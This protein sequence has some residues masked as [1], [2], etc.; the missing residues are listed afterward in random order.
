MFR[1]RDR[2]SLQRRHPTLFRAADPASDELTDPTVLPTA[3]PLSMTRPIPSRAASTTR[4]IMLFS[5]VLRGLFYAVFDFVWTI[6]ISSP[7][8]VCTPSLS[9]AFCHLDSERY[10]GIS[11][12]TVPPWALCSAR[13][14]FIPWTVASFHERVSQTGTFKLRKGGAEPL[15]VLSPNRGGRFLAAPTTASTPVQSL[16]CRSLSHPLLSQ[17]KTLFRSLPSRPISLRYDFAISFV[18]SPP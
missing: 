6:V 11:P 5:W 17:L 7:G 4:P 16:P 3:P 13:G 15:S 2:N 14:Q 9:K 18:S 8:Y 10:L 1:W 12:A